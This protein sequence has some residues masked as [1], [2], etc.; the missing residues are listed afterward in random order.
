MQHQYYGNTRTLRRKWPSLVAY[1]ENLI[2]SA[3]A[4]S[5]QHEGLAVCDKFEDWL[6]GNAQSC[7]TTKDA[8][9]CP[10]GAEMG[11]FNYVLGLRAM[12]QIAGVV[13]NSSAAARY[14][15]YATKGTKEFHAYFYNSSAGRYGGDIGATQSLSLPALKIGSAPPAVYSGLVNTI[16][17]NLRSIGYTLAVGAVTSKILFNMLSENGLHESA[18]RTAINTE[19]PSIGH[20]WK[21]WNATTCY[22]AFPNTNNATS[23][24]LRNPPTPSPFLFKL[25]SVIFAISYCTQAVFMS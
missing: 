9:D 18:L 6:C 21:K 3:E 25:C 8:P 22:E 11:G 16:D 15:W 13:G 12:A 17:D 14:S 7:C 4:A 20:W 19:E 1:Q 24:Y 10:V 2:S 23:T 5:N